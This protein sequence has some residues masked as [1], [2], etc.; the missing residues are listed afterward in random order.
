M[1]RV[2]GAKG[3]RKNLQSLFGFVYT[4]RVALK[5]E[6]DT[7]A[8]LLELLGKWIDRIDSL[9][10]KALKVH[11]ALTKPVQ[12][13]IGLVTGSAD[14]TSGDTVGGGPSIEV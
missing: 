13:L 3:L 14:E 12:F 9:S 8:V 4:E 5:K 1:Y 11:K 6:A 7:H 10:A 2:Y